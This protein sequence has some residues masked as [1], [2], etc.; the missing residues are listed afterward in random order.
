M[1]PSNSDSRGGEEREEYG[2]GLY[3]KALADKA[4]WLSR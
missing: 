4:Q 3:E 2:G 1:N